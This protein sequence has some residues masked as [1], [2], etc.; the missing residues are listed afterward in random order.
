MK[1]HYQSEKNLA[2]RIIDDVLYIG[3]VD[4]HEEAT[5]LLKNGQ[6]LTIRIDG[7]EAIIDDSLFG[8]E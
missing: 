1:I 3:I 4:T 8:K 2:G 5:V 6:E 7:I